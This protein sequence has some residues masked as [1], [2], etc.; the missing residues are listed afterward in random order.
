R[1]AAHRSQPVCASCHSAMDPLGLPLE[2]FDAIGAFRETEQGRAIDTTGDLDGVPFDGPIGL[3]ELLSTSDRASACLVRNL[4]RYAAGRSESA[5]EEPMIKALV[6][7]F[8][9]NGLDMQGLMLDLV[10]SDGFRYVAAPE[11]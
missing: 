1:L 11:L 5:S 9:T 8:R 4:Y 3:G 7:R 6:E 2:N 10:S